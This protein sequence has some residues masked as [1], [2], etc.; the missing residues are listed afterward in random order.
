[1]DPVLTPG[2]AHPIFFQDNL[3][4]MIELL[5]NGGILLLPTDTTWG[6]SCD[7]TNQEA[8]QRLR[9]LQ[10]R[11]TQAPFVL[12]APD[13]EMVSSYVEHIHPRMDLLLAYHTR[14]VTIIYEQGKNLP[15]HA[16]APD[17]SVAFR[18]VRDEF[19]LRLLR[20]FGK[21]LISTLPV[22]Y[23][24]PAPEH[25]GHINSD[26][27]GEVDYVVRHRRHDLEP[28]APSTII[29]LGENDE[30]EFIRE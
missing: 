7:A 22:R 29:R 25:Y 27:I 13:L 6:L 3:E 8:I 20:V 10:H 2:V 17:G 15:G 12:L 4:Q 28:Q 1:M 26:I 23:G 30:F 9:D 24:H 18:V 19:C 5:N 16:V 11:P 21:P 14:P